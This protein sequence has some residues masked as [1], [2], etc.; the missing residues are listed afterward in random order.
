MA[1]PTSSS[2]PMT[3][4]TVAKEEESDNEDD[5]LESFASLIQQAVT[6]TKTEQGEKSATKKPRKRKANETVEG[7]GDEEKKEKKEDRRKIT[8]KQ[9]MAKRREK[10]AAKRQ[11]LQQ[12]IKEETID[13]EVEEEES[14]DENVNGALKHPPA[15]APISYGP[16]TKATKQEQRMF[17][18][19]FDPFSFDESNRMYVK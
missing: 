18:D 5:E 19:N 17:R 15:P 4:D 16:I 1:L 13:E 9:N 10:K 12:E 3:L 8:S 14:S 6:K 11:R 7:K 2:V